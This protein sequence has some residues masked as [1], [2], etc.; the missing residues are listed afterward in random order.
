M[1]RPIIKHE[2]A[3]VRQWRNYG[4][5]FPFAYAWAWVRAGFSY[6]NNRF[7]VEAREI[8]TYPCHWYKSE[9]ADF[10]VW[11][12]GR[13]AT[14]DTINEWEPIRAMSRATRR[15]VNDYHDRRVLGK[16]RFRLYLPI[17]PEEDEP[18]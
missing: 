8:E 11:L 17:R 5:R 4:W 7:E 3:H 14:P 13:G 18:C 2:H 1:R 10:K 9:I 12:R 15:A 16:I 6:R